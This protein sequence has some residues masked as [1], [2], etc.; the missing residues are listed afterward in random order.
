M[1]YYKSIE[2]N[3]FDLIKQATLQYAIEKNH[4][5]KFGFKFINWAEYVL[6]CPQILTAFSMYNLTPIQGF[7]IVAYS[8]RDAPLHIDYT[9]NT[10]PMCRIN[11]PI[12]NCEGSLT[13]FYTGG[14]YVP[15]T[16]NNNGEFSFT[17]IDDISLATKVAEVEILKPT[18]IRIQ[19]PHRVVPNLNA[20]PRITLS[21]VMNRDPVFLLDE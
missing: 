16:E 19:E 17:I 11:I 15:R 8:L 2:M 12:L 21:L 18:V 14:K 1:K 20:V 7:F 13:E 10:R 4:I 6:S 5:E 9:S 3:D